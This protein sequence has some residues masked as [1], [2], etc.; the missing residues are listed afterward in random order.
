MKQQQ[1]VPDSIEH[2]S[3]KPWSDYTAA[4]YTLEQWHAACLI[5]LHDGPPT[6]KSECKLPVKTPGGALNRNGVHAAASVLAGGRGGVHAPSEKTAAARRSIVRLYGQLGEKP[7]PSMMHGEE[8]VQK[9]LE[10][11]GVKG[12]KW[13]VRR[14]RTSAT[15]SKVDKKFTS[16]DFK[17]TQSLRGRKPQQL[18]NKQLKDLNERMN[19]EQ[20]FRRMN[21]RL[22]DKGHNRVKY[23]LAFGTTAATAGALTARF[24]KTPAGQKT[25]N[26]GRAVL[27]S[28]GLMKVA[29]KTIPEARVFA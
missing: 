9:V 16:S 14:R 4:D 23:L 5:H 28:K 27:V 6:S 24:L 13:G 19:L 22:V 11:H 1:T 8:A 18:T 12:Q 7:P 3:E 17:R 26:K 20:N 10:H 21:P 29:T 15:S 25:V 2:I